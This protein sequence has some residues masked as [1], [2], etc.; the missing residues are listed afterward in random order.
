MHCHKSLLYHNETLWIK[1]VAS[2]NSDNPKRAY[3]GAELWELIGCLLLNNIN[4]F[5]DPSNHGLYQDDGLII[6][7]NCT[8][9]K[10]DVIWKKL[11]WLFNKF[12]LNWIYK[13]I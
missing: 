9:R 12:G 8:P 3:D 5:I 6:V 1:K 7:D 10:G 2:G 11:Y 4:K 13:P